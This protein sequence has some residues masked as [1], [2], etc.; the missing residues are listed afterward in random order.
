[1]L[2][3]LFVRESV[4]AVAVSWFFSRDLKL[5]LYV[6]PTKKIQWVHRVASRRT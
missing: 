5:A 3:S 4:Q 1:M 2:L 6:G